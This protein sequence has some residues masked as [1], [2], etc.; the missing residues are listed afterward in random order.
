M[1]RIMVSTQIV[2]FEFKQETVVTGGLLSNDNV[3]EASLEAANQQGLDIDV[4]ESNLGKYVVSIGGITG[5]GW[6]YT[7][8]GQPGR[9][10]QN[11]VI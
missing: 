3:L 10:Q 9:Y 8:N 2:V 5:E 7:V 1:A 6:E 4:I 11:L